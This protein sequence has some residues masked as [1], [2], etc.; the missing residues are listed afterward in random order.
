M[1]GFDWSPT[2]KEQ[3][4]LKLC[5]VF[6]MNLLI[7][8]S[9]VCRWSG[10]CWYIHKLLKFE[11]D[12]EFDVSQPSARVLLHQSIHCLALVPGRSHL[13][14]LVCKYGGRRPGR[15]GHMR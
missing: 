12:V 7:L 2:K 9:L 3:G 11:F 15:F 1:I 5:I 8:I 4:Q 10:K 6:H 14:A 13:I